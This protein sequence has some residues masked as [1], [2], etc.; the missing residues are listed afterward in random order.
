MANPT[1][2]ATYGA[3]RDRND[4]P[5]ASSGAASEGMRLPAFSYL[6]GAGAPPEAQRLEI[7]EDRFK[8]L[9]RL[10]LLSVP[11]DEPWY[12]KTNPDVRAAVATGAFSSAREH[13]V[14]AGYF[15]DRWPHPIIVDESWYLAQY[16]D[17]KAAIANRGVSSA[18]DHF[19]KYGFREGRMPSANWT[20][21]GP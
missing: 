8:A 18:Q 7:P 6:L 17:V 2:R 5:H 9:L 19:N 20:F 12:L 15:E 4:N 11:V 21:L 16:P 14:A 3:L 10:L 1:P 13:Y